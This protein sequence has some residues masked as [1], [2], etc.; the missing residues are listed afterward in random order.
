M[1]RGL[2]ILAHLIV[3]AL[4]LG[5]AE[6][7]VTTASVDGIVQMHLGPWLWEPW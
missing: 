3:V 2:W 7:Q 5:V 4:C 1:T 6:A